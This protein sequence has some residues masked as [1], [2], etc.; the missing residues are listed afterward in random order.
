MSKLET[1]LAARV[2]ELADKVAK[3]GWF[4]SARYTEEGQN[5]S[6]AEVAVIHEHGA[7]GAGIPARPFFAPTIAE[8]SA[9][10]TDKLASGARAVMAGKISAESML[11]QVGALAAGQ[12]RK[13]ISEIR[14]PAL[15]ESTLDQRRRDGYSDQPLNRTGYMIA[16]LT[17]VVTERDK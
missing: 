9:M 8:N 11:E 14:E 15:A 13:T 5:I 17:N 1:V 6:V 4:E 16:T 7:P 12:V 3:V 10:W 2:R